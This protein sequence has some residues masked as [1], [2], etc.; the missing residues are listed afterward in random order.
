[1]SRGRF[2]SLE[3]L[4]AVVSILVGLLFFHLSV[5]RA[6]SAVT[7]GQA[8]APWPDGA[9]YLDAAVS[10]A[11]GGACRIHLAGESHPS[12]YPFGFS[13]LTAGALVLGVDPA[14]APHRAN[15]AAGFALLVLTAAYLWRRKQALEAGSAVLLLATLPAFVI[16]SRSPLSEISGTL[17]IVAGVWLLYGFSRDGSLV[18]GGAGAALLALSVCFRTSNLFLFAF[19]PAASLGRTGCRWRRAWRELVVLAAAAGLGLA[20]VLAYNL[21][22]FGDPLTTGYDYWVPYWNVSRAFHYRFIAPN[23]VYDW[24][25]LIQQETL[26]TTANLYGRGSYVGPSFVLLTLISPLGLR[27]RRRFWCFAAAGLTYFSLMTAFFTSDAR[28]LF[29]LFVLAAPVAASGLVGVWRRWWKSAKSPVAFAA[30]LLF[31]TAVLGWPAGGRPDSVDFLWPESPDAP[32]PAYLVVRQLQ[33][34]HEDSPRLV[35]TDLPPPYVHAVSPPGT[36]VASLYD[37]HLFRFNPEAFVFAAPARRRLVGEALAAGRSVWALTH[38][39]DI[40][41]IADACPAPAGYTW[42]VVAREQR[43]TGIARLVTR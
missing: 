3:S 19:I 37:D 12:R 14:M 6:S 10:L 41:E 22:T 7:A 33:R 15:Q 17:L 5:V 1:M 40:L 32:S 43:T 38:A 4:L 18:R 35:L 29:P 13:L 2:R 21:V 25:E 23:L 24:R 20:P 8:G 28:L 42:E 34:L 30:A 11:R 31:A 16:L 9:E 39:H 36:I 26:F 27:V